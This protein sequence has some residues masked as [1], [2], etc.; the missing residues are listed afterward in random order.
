[1]CICIVLG[2]ISAIVCY[3]WRVMSD[4]LI[5]FWVLLFIVYSMV[6]D[7]HYN[8]TEFQTSFVM[9]CLFILFMTDRIRQLIFLILA[10]LVF[11]F[12]VKITVYEQSITFSALSM[13][14]FSA[15]VTL[16]ICALL[17]ML[18]LYTQTIQSRIKLSNVQNTRLLDAMHEGLLILS[19]SS[20]NE[21]M[22]CNWPA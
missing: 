5:Y 21:S 12:A 11:S 17:S 14:L 8:F 2:A 15:M 16:A 6:P 22:F 20:S 18:I 7:Y 9:A 19:K 4:Y 3:K 13:K 10:Q 1:M